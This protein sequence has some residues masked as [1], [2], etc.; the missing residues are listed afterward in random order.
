MV[1]IQGRSVSGGGFIRGVLCHHNCSIWFAKALIGFLCKADRIGLFFGV[2][3]GRETMRLS[4]IQFADYLI[5]FADA[6]E[7][8]MLNLKYLRRILEV[9]N[10]LKL[11]MSKTKLYGV[12]VEDSIVQKWVGMVKCSKSNI[13]VF[14][15]TEVDESVWL[16]RNESI[17]NKKMFLVDLMF[18]PA[19]LRIGHWCKGNLL[20]SVTSVLDFTRESRLCSIQVCSVQR[21][22]VSLWI[23]PEEGFV[24]FNVDATVKGGVSPTTIGEIL[25]DHTGVRLHRFSKY[26]GFSDPTSVELEGILE[27]CTCYAS[28]PWTNSKPLVIESDNELAVNWIKQPLLVPVSFHELSEA[29]HGERDELL[30]HFLILG[31]CGSLLIAGS[32][33]MAG[34]GA[35]VAISIKS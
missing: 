9:V 5:V 11:N 17:F 13:C 2:N 4:H 26:I 29:L 33:L 22:K 23:A 25:R 12:N 14:C 20:K 3:V 18:E 34:H 31:G 6:K 7:R 15:S 1:R 19:V 16:S 32:L 27:A 10:G 28:S 21:P 35:L 24:K 8:L 30:M